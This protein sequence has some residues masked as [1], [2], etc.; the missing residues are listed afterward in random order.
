METECLLAP[1][2]EDREEGRRVAAFPQGQ[3]WPRSRPSHV[4]GPAALRATS[5]LSPGPLGAPP[6]WAFTVQACLSRP[7]ASVFSSRKRGEERCLPAPRRPEG[8]AG[9]GSYACLFPLPLSAYPT[10]ALRAAPRG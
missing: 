6:S 2:P 9:E 8:P 10:P 4:A 5:M 7:E 1:N 3:N